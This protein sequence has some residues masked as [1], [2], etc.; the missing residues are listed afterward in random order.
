M[1]TF[2]EGCLDMLKR[3]PWIRT[4]VLR[5]ELRPG[6]CVRWWRTCVRRL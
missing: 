2:T 5:C 6:P 3:Y 1:R 4:L